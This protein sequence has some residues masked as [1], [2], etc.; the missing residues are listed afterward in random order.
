MELASSNRGGDRSK[1]AAYELFFSFLQEPGVVEEDISTSASS[2]VLPVHREA[3][4]VEH[5]AYRMY[6]ILLELL[7]ARFIWEVFT[8]HG[9]AWLTW[10]SCAPHGVWGCRVHA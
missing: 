10:I 6:L 9:L 2:E 8:W 7:F 5:D 3:P 1:G 4:P